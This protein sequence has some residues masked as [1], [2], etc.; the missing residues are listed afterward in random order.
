MENKCV[1]LSSRK[2]FQENSLLN[3]L[4]FCVDDLADRLLLAHMELWKNLIP[5]GVPDDR[6]C[7]RSETLL[8]IS[9]FPLPV[10]DI[11]SQITLH[12]LSC[13]MSLSQ[14]GIPWP[15][16]ITHLMFPRS[17]PFSF[18]VLLLYVCCLYV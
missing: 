18:M 13:Q 3:V 11:G 5:Q 15:S 9:L 8:K 14:R 10:L 2:V 6:T 17:L 12:H 1:G 4:P 7:H 16:S